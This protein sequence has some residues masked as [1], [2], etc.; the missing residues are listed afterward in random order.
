VTRKSASE[1]VAKLLKLAKSSTNPHEASTARSQ[2][3]KLIEEHGLTDADLIGGE[4]SAAFDDLVD[5][6]KKA[7]AQHPA[8]PDGLFGSLGIVD[9]VLDK[10]KNIGDSDK[11]TRLKQITTLIR[12]ASFIAGSQPIVAEIKT[13]LDNTL[14][15]HG[16]S[17]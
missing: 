17:L 12:T 11:A 6:V 3:N 4:M 10:I 16:L 7:I 14:K 2:A 8:I 1:K 5:S 9:Q 15:N 13:I